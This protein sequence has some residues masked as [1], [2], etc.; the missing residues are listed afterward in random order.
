MA[1][2]DYISVSTILNKLHRELPSEDINE[3]DVI[4]WIGEAMSELHVDEVLADRVCFLKVDNFQA[5]IPVGFKYVLQLAKYN[6]EIESDCEEDVEPIDKEEICNA[7]EDAIENECEGNKIE[8]IIDRIFNDLDISYRPVFDMSFKFQT[9][10]ISN[11]YQEKFEPIRLANHTLFNTLVCGDESLYNRCCDANHEYT[12]VG[13]QCRVLRFSF[14]EGHVAM[15]YKGNPVDEDGY[16]L[17]P[18]TFSHLNA[19]NYYVRWKVAEKLSWM[20]REGFRAL[21]QD[22]EQHWLK[23]VKQAVNKSRIT[24]TLDDFQD[25]LEETYAM[26]PNYRKYY[27]FF[28]SLGKSQ[29][30]EYLNTRGFRDGRI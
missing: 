12:I 26:I 20:G 19:V 2:F 1:K 17:I 21:S 15:S 18:D 28:G 29:S 10:R 4:E 9:W 11:F 8:S 16:P 3:A 23:Y 30:R 13:E 27:G 7:C 25:Q 24:M 22:S 5:E 6:K 14:E